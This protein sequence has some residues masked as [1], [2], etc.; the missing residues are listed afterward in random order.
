VSDFNTI[1]HAVSNQVAKLVKIADES[2][3]FEV[4]VDK[5][6]LWDLY[7]NSFPEGTDPIYKTR[8]EHNCNCCKQFIRQCGGVIAFKNGEMHTVWDSSS[9]LDDHYGVVASKLAEYIKTKPIKNIFRHFQKDVGV[10]KSR[11]FA[12]QILSIKSKRGHHQGRSFNK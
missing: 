6:E 5:N 7:L 12:I 9:K 2:E 1:K 8:T 11:Q 3:L 10:D 4:D